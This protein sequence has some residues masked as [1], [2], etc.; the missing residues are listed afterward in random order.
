MPVSKEITVRSRYV[1]MSDGYTRLYLSNKRVVSE[2]R[3]IMEQYLGRKLKP[4]ELIHHKD[5]DRSN[6]E[7]SNLELTTRKEHM[8]THEVYKEGRT[9][10]QL[11]CAWCGKDFEREKRQVTAKVKAGQTN[12]FCSRVCMGHGP[13]KSESVV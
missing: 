12:F 1:G 13:K 6:N 11:T 8:K 5:G 3:W 7:I 10:I 9:Q 4:S 2:H